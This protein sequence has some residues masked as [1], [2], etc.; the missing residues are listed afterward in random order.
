MNKEL[1][2]SILN[3]KM[4]QID[5]EYGFTVRLA[6]ENYWTKNFTK[7]AII[8]YKK[9]MYLAATSN[10]MV[11]PSEIIDKVWHLHL[12]YTKSYQEFCKLLGKQ[13][14]H[15]PSTHKRGEFQ[16]FN[17]AKQ[18]TKNVY[19]ENFGEQPIFFWEDHDMF[20]GLNLTKSKYK[21]RSSIIVAI[22]I[23]IALIIPFFYLLKPIIIKIGNPEFIFYL[24]FLAVLCYLT[25][26]VINGILLKR[27]L[28]QANKNSF[29]FDLNSFEL[30]YLKTQNIS[31]V[32]H[33]HFDGL[34]RKGLVYAKTDGIIGINDSDLADHYTREELTIYTT[35]KESGNSNFLNLAS[36]LSGKSIFYNTKSAMDAFRKYFLKSRKFA[37][38]FFINFAFLSLLTMISFIRLSLG[39]IREK[40]ISIIFIITAVLCFTMYQFLNR[41]SYKISTN[42]IP[43]MYKN[44]FINIDQKEGNQEWNYF[45]AGTYALSSGLATLINYKPPKKNIDDYFNGCSS[46]SSCSSCGGCGGCG[47]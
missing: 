41:L 23:F 3:F 18:R 40:P 32:V 46:C 12:V 14:Q 5:E 33:A 4:D 1:W 45:L 6:K 19:Q 17:L 21:L 44:D 26:E 37:Q 9:F 22:A 30:L 43:R 31:D 39:F 13:I 25:L 28:K 34:F 38:L 10:R 24:I 7:L 27:I 20:Q 42:I 35:I 29:I 16:R 8:E 2:Y 15:I 36:A 11:S 47:D